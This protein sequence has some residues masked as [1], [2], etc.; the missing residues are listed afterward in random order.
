MNRNSNLEIALHDGICESYWEI[1]DDLD[2][3]CEYLGH[4]ITEE[5]MIK[6]KEDVELTVYKLPE[7]FKLVKALISFNDAVLID[8]RVERFAPPA[9]D[10]SMDLYV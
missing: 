8:H 4:E 2:T 9:D 7:Q 3:I 6:N 1:K 5:G 10:P